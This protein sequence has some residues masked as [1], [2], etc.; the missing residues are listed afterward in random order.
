MRIACHVHVVDN[1]FIVRQARILFSPSL[2][3]VQLP[4]MSMPTILTSKTITFMWTPVFPNCPSA[5]YN[6]LASNCG[7]CPTTTNY[8]TVTCS[9]VPTDGRMCT[10]AVQTMVRGNIVGNVSN[11]VSVLLRGND[12]PSRKQDCTAAIVSASLLATVLAI[13]ATVFSTIF[14]I[15]VIPRKEKAKREAT[16]DNQDANYEDISNQ[17]TSPIVISTRKNIAYGQVHNSISAST[18][19]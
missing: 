11:S 7:S 17:K 9:D 16:Q 6:I 5:H 3:D 1:N 8:T 14:I 19:L 10:F 12:I 13:C 15:R 18:V 4:I 2:V